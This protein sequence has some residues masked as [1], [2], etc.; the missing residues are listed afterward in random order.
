MLRRRVLAITFAAGLAGLVLLPGSGSASASPLGLGCAPYPGGQTICSGAVASWDG[1]PLDVDVTQPATAGT[2]HPLLLMLHGFGNNKHEWESTSDTGD[3][4]DK[5]HWNSHWFAEH[6]YYVVTYTARGFRDDGADRSDEPATPAGSGTQCEPPGGSACLPGGTIRI[7]STQYEIRDTQWLAA[8]V[9]AAFPGV[10]ANEVAVTGGSYGGGESWLQASQPDWTFPHQ[11]DPSL[12]VLHLQ[13]AVPKYPWTDLAYSLAPNGHGG[14]PGLNDLYASSQ[15]TPASDGV[16]N[17]VGLEKQSYVAGLYALGTK[18]GVFEESGLYPPTAE[19]PTPYT[20]WL[21]RFEAGEPYDLPGRTDDPTLALVRADFAKFHSAYYQPSW[22]ALAAGHREVAVFSISGWTDDL[23]PPVESFRMYKLLKSI[24]PYWPVAVAVADVG[25]SRAQNKP[26]VW[27]RLNGQAWQFLESM[28]A[29]S[30]GER[31]TAYSEPTLCGSAD[32]TSADQLT[33]TAPEGLSAGTLTVRYSRGTTLAPDAGE[34]DPNGPQTDA[35]L[36]P[37]LKSEPCR[38]AA[39]PTAGATGYTAVSSPLAARATMVGIG[40]VEVGYSAVP[41]APLQAAA[42]AERLW[43]V[44]PD[45]TAYLVSRGVYRLDFNGYDPAAGTVRVPFYGNH[46][47]FQPGDT[48]RIDLVQADNATYRA[49]N[50]AADSALALDPPVLVLPLREAEQ[51]AL[52]GS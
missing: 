34:D 2:T 49:P 47:I 17:P 18:Q 5:W 52:T 35:I 24:D 15:G 38:T 19:G 31:T 7:K 13:V 6:G 30:H 44:K 11:Q 28:I 50:A 12:P 20:G 51:V 1:S 37:E 29:G 40:Y 46:W 27:Q 39:S 48:I 3:G 41:G 22:P 16:G 36:G 45:G 43:D 14:G 8:Q 26:A 25:H 21:A 32:S 9:A 4:A 33:A 10:D 23:F 42:I